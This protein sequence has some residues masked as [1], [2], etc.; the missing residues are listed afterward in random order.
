MKKTY[1]IPSMDTFHVHAEAVLNGASR[2]NPEEDNPSV[3]PS[4]D[5]YDGE[6]SGRRNNKSVWDDDFEEEGEDY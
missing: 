3:T 6:F 5:P 4:D 1:L 2:L